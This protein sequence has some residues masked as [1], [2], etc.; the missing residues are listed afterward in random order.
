MFRTVLFSIVLSLAVGQNA[1]SF[2]RAWCD[3][4]A[5][6]ASG[7][8]YEEST[9]SASVAGDK[10]CD[11]EVGVGAF[12]REEGARA[13]A[14]RD[15]SHALSVPRYQLR[16]S[17]TDARPDVESGS[18]WVLGKQHLSLTLRI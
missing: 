8:H 17:I 9:V 14:V 1:T 4:Q 12:V 2:C 7:C 10:S 5:A 6:A 11:D 15:M 16:Q 3:L 18:G 13:V